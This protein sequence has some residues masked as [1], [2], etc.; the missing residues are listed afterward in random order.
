MLDSY[1]RI[2]EF[3]Q[4]YQCSL[5]LACYGVALQRLADVYADR[6]IFP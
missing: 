1:E 3:A 2:A 5:R 4:T 6:E